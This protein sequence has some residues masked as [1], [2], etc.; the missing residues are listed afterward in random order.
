MTTIKIRYSTFKSN[1]ITTKPKTKYVCSF[2]PNRSR[3][4][5]LYN[6]L[7]VKLFK[8]LAKEMPLLLTLSISCIKGEEE[9]S[10]LFLDI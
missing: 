4:V 10:R 7:I 1:A 9:S 8:T 6:V 5:Y 3:Y 2:L